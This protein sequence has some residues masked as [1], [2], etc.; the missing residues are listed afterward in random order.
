VVMPNGVWTA[1]ESARREFERL[2]QSRLQRVRGSRFR[3]VLLVVLSFIVEWL[4]PVIV[5]RGRCRW[6]SR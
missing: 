1:G 2:R 4:A 3:V 5:S 6:S